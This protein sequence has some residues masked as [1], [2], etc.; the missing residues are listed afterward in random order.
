[1]SG[2]RVSAS[3]LAAALA[4]A[5]G[6]VALPAH[7]ATTARAGTSRFTTTIDNPYLPFRPG[8]V[9]R[10][11][12]SSAEGPGTE[13][14]T[15]LH[16]TRRVDG[17]G[18]VVVRDVARVRGRVVEMTFDWYA[19]DRKGNVWYFGEATRELSNGKV[20]SHEGSWEAGKH[21]AR[22]GIVM[23]AHPRVGDVYRQEFLRGVAEDTAKV[24]SRNAHAA[25]PY[26]SFRHVLKTKDYSPLEPTV[27]EHKFYARGV[28]SVLEVMVKGGRERLEL[29]SVSR[30]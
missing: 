4:F 7:G 13:V 17:V 24:L 22:A 20:V 3:V 2:H 9:M 10:Y 1:M 21:G 14:V 23:E 28:G 29:V 16:R 8:T 25:V 30:A 11:R 5:S 18:T 12:S 19:Q 27:V 26:G 15:V 6:A